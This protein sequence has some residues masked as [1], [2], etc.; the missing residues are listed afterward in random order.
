MDWYCQRE[1][2]KP[3]I[4]TDLVRPDD[5]GVHGVG[6]GG[7]CRSRH[8]THD[9]AVQVRDIVNRLWT[10]D[11][12]RT[13]IKVCVFDVKGGHKDHFHFQVHEK[14]RTRDLYLNAV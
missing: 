14:T 9:Q 11:P 4:I 6:R 7:D 13:W 1:F 12:T 3:L 10:Y 5:P 8:L 2:G